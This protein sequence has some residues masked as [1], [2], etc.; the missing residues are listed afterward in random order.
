[1]SDERVVVLTGDVDVASRAVVME[2]LQEALRELA[3]GTVLVLDLSAVTFLDSS[4]LSCI[5]ETDVEARKAGSTL[6]L[7]GAGP[8]IFRVLELTGMG[9]FLEAES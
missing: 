2:Q 6:R 3:A 9:G 7:R 4:G 1:M 5:A 8:M